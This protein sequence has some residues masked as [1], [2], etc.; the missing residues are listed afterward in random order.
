[1]LSAM[2]KNAGSLII[3]I[4]FG[5]II[6]VFV[7]WGVGTDRS[8]QA[9]RVAVV[10]GEPIPIEAYG[11]AYENLLEQ[12]R[13]RFG[14]QL[15]ED[16]I[17]LLNLK[18]QAVNQLVDE[19]V[20]LD[21][22]E[23][24]GLRV[25]TEELT[26]AI[27]QIPVFQSNGVF[28][29]ERYRQVLAGSRLTPEGFEEA[30]R[31]A[32]LVQKLTGFVARSAVVSDAEAKAW[33]EWE[34]ATVDVDYI[35]FA[36]EDYPDATVTDEEVAAAFEE[37]Q[38]AYRTDPRARAEY[39]VFRPE[40]FKDR[41]TVDAEE[42]REYYDENEGEFKKP[43]TVTARH[44][45]I[46][47][48]EDADQAAVDQ[49]LGRA[50]AVY[51]KAKSGEDF[52]ELAKTHSEGPTR[53]AGGF[54]GSFQRGA[55]VAPFE[56]KAFSMEAGDVS[57]PVR[58]PF[59]WHIIKVEGKT[60]ETTVGLPEAENRIRGTL[61]DRK[62]NLLA[63]DAAQEAYD[64]TYDTPSIAEVAEGMDVALSKTG[65]F[66][67]SG[68]EGLKDAAR[69]ADIVFGLEVGEISEVE[70]LSDGYYLIQVAERK[71]PE[72]PPLDAVED[73]VRGDLLER[74]RRD[75]AKADAEEAMGALTAGT[76]F[77]AVAEAAGKSVAETGFFERRGEVGALGADRAF[78]QAAFQLSG[79]RPHPDG[80]VEGLEGFYLIRFR[81]RKLPS[82]E[83]FEAE[84]DAVKAQLLDRKRMQL[85]QAW[86]EGA[87]ERSEIAIEPEYA[88]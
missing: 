33:F 79:E 61:A 28:D 53:D 87:R 40:T 5:V 22:A 15:D 60:P 20:M 88:Q 80:V 54:L 35:R 73:E 14:G 7:L 42:V 29:A 83:A 36:P 26:S 64:A 72:V 34:N 68:P 71:P 49:A 62:A 85:F 8:Q 57:E 44:I 41:V 55:M 13:Q 3:K 24:L 43:E 10:N 16:M 77:E 86:L 27:R 17:R 6:I 23:A 48:A 67:R 63:Y 70:E 52:A 84:A 12:T 46:K 47:V 51:E 59:G 50:Q 11:R 2:R 78:A 30:Q 19:R 37:N 56:E 21:E 4:L 81:E 75:L 74:K 18:G 39:L 66:D 82:A 25:G 58:T 9:N 32:M 45:L 65:L 31:Q 69:F 76:D 1:M 38:D